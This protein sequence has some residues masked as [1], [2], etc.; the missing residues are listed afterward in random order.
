ML[1]LQPVPPRPARCCLLW[2]QGGVSPAEVA[3][4]RNAGAESI[5]LGPTVLRTALAGAAALN[6]LGPLTNRWSGQQAGNMGE[7]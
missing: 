7:Q 6:A 2:R 4:F 5:V 1:N 3:Q